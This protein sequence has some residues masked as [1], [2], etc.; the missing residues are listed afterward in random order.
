MNRIYLVEVTPAIRAHF[1]QKLTYFSLDG[2]L[3]KGQ[4]VFVEGRS[5]K[6]PGVID[7]IKPL[8]GREAVKQLPFKIKK[9]AQQN[10][11]IFVGEE[12]I[13][14]VSN[15]APR[16]LVSESEVLGS[17]LPAKLEMISKSLR[18]K[19]CLFSTNVPNRKGEILYLEGSFDERLKYY[20]RVV[21]GKLRGR[22]LII[23]VPN[24]HYS[25]LL[26]Q[27]L[28]SPGGSKTLRLDDGLKAKELSSNIDKLQA[29]GES[30]LIVAT[31]TYVVLAARNVGAIVVEK[32]SG[33]YRQIGSPYLDLREYVKALALA[34]GVKLYFGDDCLSLGAGVSDRPR[35]IR[36]PTKKL[37]SVVVD[38]K[39]T[40]TTTNVGM[41]V[42]TAEFRD[43]IDEALAKKTSILA[44]SARRGVSNITVCT[45][46]GQNV[47]CQNCKTPLVLHEGKGLRFFLCHHCYKKS[48]KLTCPNCNSWRLKSLG[49][50]IEG[51]ALQ[52]KKAY[53]SL[54]LQ[55]I[56][57][58]TDKRLNP[59][60]QFV[61]VTEALLPQ[62][63]TRF[64]T[65]VIAYIDSLLALP[66]FRIRERVFRRIVEARNLAKKTL[67]VQ[68]RRTNDPIFKQAI[69]G[70]TET[71]KYEE[72]KSRQ[73][74][75]YPPAVH[76]IKLTLPAGSE[77][78]NR[79]LKEEINS[80]LRKWKP[81]F[82][83]PN[84][85]IIRQPLLGWP[86]AELLNALLVLRKKAKLELDP[87]SIL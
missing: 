24:Q 81:L 54:D 10:G 84:R 73:R 51:L 80:T 26:S 63:T 2:S 29:S 27:K 38:L 50:G 72:L 67:L 47:D 86:N 21:R 68:T 62:L 6:F 59:D 52:N 49:I 18:H 9:L 42:L 78:K 33:S 82:V 41:D 32:E 34:L 25:E 45:D 36:L 13:K 69:A 12:L 58:D 4:I 65:V 79:A 44:I 35:M 20:E 16:L 14:L 85:V 46:C 15:L 66:E 56:S 43:L 74:F 57:G 5:K 31:P 3:Q 87:E 17:I 39:L 70:D 40:T 7:S 61:L 37:T 11:R 55:I 23:V 75:G 22:S 71:F 48:T 8:I 64:D 28:E 77:Q 19:T 30:H 1:A 76:V 83:P 60:S 53:P